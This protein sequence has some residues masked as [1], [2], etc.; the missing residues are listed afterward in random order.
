MIPLQSYTIRPHLAKKTVSMGTYFFNLRRHRTNNIKDERKNNITY[1][2]N[3][4]I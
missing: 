4:T 3:V 2:D 1:A